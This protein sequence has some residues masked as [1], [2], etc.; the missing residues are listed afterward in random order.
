MK[1]RTGLIRR[2][3]V[4]LI[5]V[6]LVVVVALAVYVA[7]YVSAR[8]S[9]TEVEAGTK[10]SNATQVSDSSASGSAAVKF[11]SAPVV[12][13][14]CVGA[15]YEPGGPDPW[16]GCWPGP[17]NTGY[18]KGLTGDTRTPVTLT[19]Y[20]GPQEITSC[21]VV[22]DKKIT[23]WLYIRAGNGTHSKDTPC[24]TIKNSW[25]KGTIFSDDI[26]AGPVLIED[27]EVDSDGDLPY[28][29]NIGRYNYFTYRVNS[30]GGQGVIKCAAYCET[31][32][33]W[34]HAMTV[35]NAYHYNAIGGNGMEAGSW[36][37][38]HNWAS[39]G[40]WES[41]QPGIDSDAGCSAVIGFYGDFAPI[42]NITINRNF[43]VSAFDVSPSGD[44]RQA[45]YCLNPGYYVGKPNPDPTNM[46]IT[47]NIFGRGLSGKCGVFGP[48]N[49]INKVGLGSTN[50]W[51][52]NRYTDGTV[53]NKI[54][55]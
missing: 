5:S 36:N 27:T 30:H 31:K 18:P 54:E 25:V 19:N 4:L 23:S 53:I 12:T 40:D 7:L 6:A 1:A 52:G 35:G 46:V 24:V 42:R 50:T 29:E 10:S 15:I 21:G 38:E 49:S 11:G 55:E 44:W 2:K 9:S 45:A 33:N 20:T 48:T 8:P 13:G 37:I 51:S 3:T 47:D 14:N 17:Q 34:I 26:N 39:C 22:I 41:V 32:D 16:G 43:L 28:I